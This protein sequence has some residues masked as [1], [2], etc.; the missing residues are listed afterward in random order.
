VQTTSPRFSEPK[1][2]RSD[3]DT[4]T[5]CKRFKTP[6]TLASSRTTSSEFSLSM[7]LLPISKAFERL[8]VA[9]QAAPSLNRI[10]R[11]NSLSFLFTEIMNDGAFRGTLRGVSASFL[12]ASFVLFP[13]VALTNK[14]NGGFIQ[15]LTTYSILD[16]ILYPLDT[17]KN[18]LYA[19][20]AT[21]LSKDIVIQT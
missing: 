8:I 17:I 11:P 20:T 5:Q 15:F 6:L 9:Y 3:Q 1:A 18:R 7:V 16:A 12:Q 14:S 19:N 21:P 13:S 4:I 2:R 10:N